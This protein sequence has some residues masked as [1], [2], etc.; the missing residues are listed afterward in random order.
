[1]TFENDNLESDKSGV[2]GDEYKRFI[3]GCHFMGC[4]GERERETLVKNDQEQVNS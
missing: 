1:M 2:S 3:A 4:E